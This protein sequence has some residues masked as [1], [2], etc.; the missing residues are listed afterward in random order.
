MKRSTE[1]SI[2]HAFHIVK[3]KLIKRLESIGDPVNVDVI[4]QYLADLIE[5]EKVP[6]DK[7]S[8]RELINSLPSENLSFNN[9]YI[10]LMLNHYLVDHKCSMESEIYEYEERYIG[11]RVSTKIIESNKFRQQDNKSKVPEDQSWD[12]EEICN[13]LKM[14]LPI[15]ENVTQISLNFVD[16]VWRVISRKFSPIQLTAQIKMITDGCLEITWIIMP[17]VAK[18]IS[19]T[20]ETHEFFKSL[21]A[22]TVVVDGDIIYERPDSAVS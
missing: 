4:T 18:K 6:K 1:F 3:E 20:A 15:E 10:L 11:Y 9:Y 8:I 13:T 12:I 17:K 21:N 7:S 14:K 22:I 2:K 16:D 19:S 5:R